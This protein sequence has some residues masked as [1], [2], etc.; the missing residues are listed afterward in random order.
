MSFWTH[1][2]TIYNRYE[3]STEGTV[4]YYRHIL[5]NCFVKRTNNQVTVGN[6]H[7]QSDDTIV[8]IPSQPNF[9]PAFDWQKLDSETKSKSVTLQTDDLI[10]FG[11]VAD[12]IDEYKAGERKNDIIN[13]YKD[14]GY[15][16]I[17]TFNLNTFLP[18]KHY[19]VK[20]G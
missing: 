9:Y 4:K 13:K 20:G 8:R 7:I 2:I 3:D 19:L 5:H 11:A 6:T 15:M 14:L 18:T 17:K 10:I 12:E 1:T 16:S